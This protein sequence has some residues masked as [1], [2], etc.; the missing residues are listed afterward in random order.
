MNEDFA[1]L[2]FFFGI[3]LTGN[4]ALLVGWT[5]SSRRA[6][7]FERHLL[8]HD[9]PAVDDGRTERTE[10]ALDALSAQVDQL[11]SGQEFL[12]RVISERLERASRGQPQDAHDLTPR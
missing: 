11:A 2:L 7:R 1:I 6:R 12:N 5:R 8:E 10:R 9:P 3:S 4:L